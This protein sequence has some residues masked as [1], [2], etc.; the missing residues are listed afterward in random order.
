MVTLTSIADK[1]LGKVLES[2]DNELGFEGDFIFRIDAQMPDNSFE[3]VLGIQKLT[4]EAA[5]KLFNQFDEGNIMFAD[6]DGATNG[7]KIGVYTAQHAVKDYNILPNLFTDIE[8][9][10]HT[11]EV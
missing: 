5:F 1:Y 3:P 6:A 11:E 2:R 10:P 7:F 4:H 9:L 8:T